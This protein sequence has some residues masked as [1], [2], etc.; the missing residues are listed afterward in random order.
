MFTLILDSSNAML[1]VGLADD[2]HVIKS[3]CYEAW[4]EQSEYMIPEID[5]LLKEFSVTK[6]DIGT[7]IVTKGPGSYTGVRIAITIAKVMALATNAKLIAI[8]SLQA[9]KEGDK[10][11]I[12]LMNARNNRSYI[13]VYQNDKVILQDRIMTNIEVKEYIN[14]HPD[15]AIRGNVSYL[16]YKN[17]DETIIEEM[18]S[19]KGL[20]KPVDD[21]LSLNPV[22]LKD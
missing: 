2:N 14:S 21:C 9:L 4:Q 15:Y 13:G 3:V 6:D 10:I 16:G 1:A 22:Y 8:S 18:F 12:C 20:I 5:S 11:S 19:L 17:T 7:I